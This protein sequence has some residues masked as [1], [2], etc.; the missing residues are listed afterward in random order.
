MINVNVLIE[1]NVSLKF[2]LISLCNKNVSLFQMN[3]TRL[4]LLLTTPNRKGMTW[5]R[6][7]QKPWYNAKMEELVGF[8]NLTAREL[9]DFT[10]H[11]I[12]RMTIECWFGR[13]VRCDE[14]G[15]WYKID[16]H[17]GV[18]YTFKRSESFEV[19]V[20]SK[21]RDWRSSSSAA[22]GA[23]GW[24]L[25]N[26]QV[27]TSGMF[28]NFYLRMVDTDEIHIDPKE[29]GW[30]IFLHDS[31]DSPVVDIR[32]HGFTLFPGWSSDVRIDLRD[33]NTLNTKQ[34]PCNESHEYSESK[35]K[36]ECFV[37]KVYESANCSLPYM[38]RKSSIL[39]SGSGF[40]SLGPVSR[41]MSHPVTTRG[42]QSIELWLK[43][44][45]H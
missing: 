18:C 13:G 41:V 32:T 20:V 37:R 8:K 38:S 42:V 43:S 19:H 22:R 24:G 44:R 34:R 25:K 21:V 29:V 12:S 15:Q 3:T 28:N 36:T 45:P 7:A 35:C 30:K 1:R 4:K 17:I 11:D 6:K 27:M 23:G 31:T 2:P 40:P 33:F 39:P 5:E 16:T 9:W 10:A 26:S 14:V